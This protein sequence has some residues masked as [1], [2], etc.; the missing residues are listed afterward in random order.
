MFWFGGAALQVSSIKRQGPQPLE[1]MPDLTQRMV[2][3]KMPD[4]SQQVWMVIGGR[5]QG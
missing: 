1:G 3:V 4:G 5:V 2:Y